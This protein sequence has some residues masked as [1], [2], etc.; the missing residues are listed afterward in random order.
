MGVNKIV[1]VFNLKRKT[2]IKFNGFYNIIACFMPQEPP[3][4]E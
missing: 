2:L 3:S 4:N 1:F